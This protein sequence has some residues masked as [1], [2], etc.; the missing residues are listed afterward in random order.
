MQNVASYE[1]NGVQL[2]GNEVLCRDTVHDDHLGHILVPIFN[3]GGAGGLGHQSVYTTTLLASSAE[4]QNLIVQLLPSDQQS[5]DFGHDDIM[6]SWLAPGLVWDS[7]VR[8]INA[9]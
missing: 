2:E 1:A 4:I 6:R 8:W 9:H 7:I 3:I 5:M